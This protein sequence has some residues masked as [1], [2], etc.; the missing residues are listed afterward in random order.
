MARPMGTTVTSEFKAPAVEKVA[1]SVEAPTV[2]IAHFYKGPDLIGTKSSCS[3]K[4]VNMYELKHGLL[5]VSK[6]E[7]RKVV[8]PFNNIVAYELL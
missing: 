3:Y 4:N 6:K 8:V 5:L 7:K 1:A 2:K